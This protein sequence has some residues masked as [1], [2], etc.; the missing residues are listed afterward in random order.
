MKI[1]KF[2]TL[3]EFINSK[4]ATERKIDNTPPLY[5]VINLTYLV[6][7]VL[8]PLRERL[9]KPILINSG[10]RCPALNDAVGGVDNSNH[11]IGC[12]ADLFI[13]NSVYVQDIVKI[14]DSRDFVPYLDELLFERTS[15]SYWIHVSHKHFGENRGIVNLN[16]KG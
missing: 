1:G 7:C 8:D 14:L 6:S 3:E 5:A 2:F 9:G 12:A 11:L 16:Y 4:V 13:P 15:S 10:Y